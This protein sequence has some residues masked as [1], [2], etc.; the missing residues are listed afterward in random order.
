GNKD[1]IHEFLASDVLDPYL[2]QYFD[3]KPY[4]LNSIGGSINAP[5][6]EGRYEHGHK[7]HRD[8][9]TFVGSGK[10]QLAV[11]LVMLDDFTEVNGATEVLLGSHHVEPFPP[12]SFVAQNRHQVC[13]TRGSVILYDG[14]IWHKVGENRSDQFRVALT[15]VFTRPNIKQ[16]LDYPRFLDA[17]YA[18]SLSPRMRQLFGFN[19]RTPS[20]MEEWYLPDGERFYRS[21]QE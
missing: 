13:G 12:E 17:S 4:I 11:A 15:L 8:I 18:A 2:S 6:K 20:S 21:D 14:D 10:R 5:P 1:G 9:R 19:A 3:C 16:Q 7:W